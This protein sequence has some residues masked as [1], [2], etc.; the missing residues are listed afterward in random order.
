[1]TIV[2]LTNLRPAPHRITGVGTKPFFTTATT[3]YQLPRPT[4]NY[5]LPT[6]NCS[7]NGALGTSVLGTLPALRAT[8][9]SRSGA[10]HRTHSPLPPTSRPVGLL[11][12][13]APRHLLRAGEA[14]GVLR[15]GPA[16]VGWAGEEA[17]GTHRTTDQRPRGSPRHGRARALRRP[18][19][20]PG[21]G[22]QVTQPRPG[23]RHATV[24]L[25]RLPVP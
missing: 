21:V 23:H 15:E 8:P 25:P 17:Q 19:Q 20:Q 7:V 12:G 22:V 11:A 9:P 1:M 10:P 3:N 18:Q 14:G 13:S 16:E 24:F 2:L 6:V 5:Q 4:T